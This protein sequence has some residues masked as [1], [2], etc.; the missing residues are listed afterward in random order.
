MALSSTGFGAN[1]ERT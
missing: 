1:T